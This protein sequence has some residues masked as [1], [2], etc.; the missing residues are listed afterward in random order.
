MILVTH[1]VVGAGLST[2][3]RAN[4]VFAFGI[5]FISHFI[6][7]AIPHWDYPLQSSTKTQDSNPLDADFII[8]K[9]F[10][11]DITK[12]GVDF[13]AG[14]LLSYL[15]FAYGSSLHSFVRSGVLWGAVGSMTPD[16]LQFVYT[17]VRKEPLISLQKFHIFM[18]TEKRLSARPVL[19]PAL[20][21][22]IIILSA[23]IF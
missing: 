18:H 13:L 14:I 9:A 6:L 1:A 3:A 22:G 15:F 11:R 5:G 17:K 10:Y 20:Q 12:I 4:P 19:G 21:G 8:G 16:F 7:D 23:I 2:V